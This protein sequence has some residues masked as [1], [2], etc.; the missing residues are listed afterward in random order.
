MP[1]PK[2]QQNNNFTPRTATST[3]TVTTTTGNIFPTIGNIIPFNPLDIY[4]NSIL[5]SSKNSK[6]HISNANPIMT[7]TDPNAGSLA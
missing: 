4:A 2:S 7:S 5:N 3:T 6:G 1:F